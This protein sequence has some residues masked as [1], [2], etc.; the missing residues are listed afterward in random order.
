MSSLEVC[1]SCF[2][3]AINHFT[4]PWLHLLRPCA[5]VCSDILEENVVQ[6]LLVSTSEISLATET[7]RL[8]LKI[9]DIVA[10]R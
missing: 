6:P 1:C 9:D 7:V 8:I 4:L 5:C 2:C 10:T 3:D